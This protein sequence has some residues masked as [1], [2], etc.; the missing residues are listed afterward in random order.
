M[1][2]PISIAASAIT[3][4]TLAARTCQAFAELRSLCKT[5]PGRL[6]ALSNEVTDINVVLIHVATIFKERACAI[7]DEQQQTISR[8][9]ERAGSKLE[10]L[11][12]ITQDLITACDRAKLAVLQAH[13]WRKEQPKLKSLQEDIKTIKCSLNVA[14]GA[15]NS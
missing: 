2:D 4:A 13:T 11:H 9:L 3:V 5:L 6:H 14:L 15:S 10:D 1:M 12:R 8:L 7:D